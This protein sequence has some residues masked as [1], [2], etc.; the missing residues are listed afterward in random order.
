ML[1]EGP[2]DDAVKKEQW[3]H[4]GRVSKEIHEAK[5]L[6]GRRGCTLF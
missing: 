2:G 4:S 3:R 5:V 6:S 1:E